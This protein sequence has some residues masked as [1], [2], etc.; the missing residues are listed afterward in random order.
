[1]TDPIER[2][3]KSLREQQLGLCE[4]WRKVRLNPSELL[5]N[6]LEP[7]KA[8]EQEVKDFT[9]TDSLS[10]E[11]WARLQDWYES[12]RHMREIATKLELAQIQDAR[13]GFMLTLGRT[14]LS[15]IELIA[16]R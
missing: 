7:F 13:R 5:L 14:D 3:G 16:I 11:A 9:G 10:G 4:E 12:R 2:F 8:W 6:V 15:C 1:M